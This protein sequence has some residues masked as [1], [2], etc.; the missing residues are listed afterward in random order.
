MEINIIQY[1]RKCSVGGRAMSDAQWAVCTMRRTVQCCT[2]TGSTLLI[3][4]TFQLVFKAILWTK[5]YRENGKQGNNLI[6]N[7]IEPSVLFPPLITMK[8]LYSIWR[9]GLACSEPIKRWPLG[10]QNGLIHP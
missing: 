3:F 5:K 10:G 1:L 6:G 7:A 8:K 4:F 9:I 2:E